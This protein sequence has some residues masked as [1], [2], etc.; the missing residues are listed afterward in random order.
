MAVEP[1]IHSCEER[2]P[3]EEKKSIPQN[4]SK[5]FPAKV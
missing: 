5:F 3:A 2:V 1:A 4:G